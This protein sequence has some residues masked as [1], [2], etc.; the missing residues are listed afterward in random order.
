VVRHGFDVLLG[1]QIGSADVSLMP[2]NA[3]RMCFVQY[4]LDALSNR[5]VSH[6]SI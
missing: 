5:T 3:N 1:V 6:I 4:V 2:I